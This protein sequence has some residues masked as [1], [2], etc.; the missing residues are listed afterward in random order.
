MASFSDDETV[1]H[2]SLWWLHEGNRAIRT[3]QWKAVAAK[4][5]PWELY[6]LETDRGEQSN[7]AESRPEILSRLTRQWDATTAEFTQLN[8]LEAD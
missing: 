5:Q 2:E 7:M 8:S 3:G 6:D 1:L 4:D